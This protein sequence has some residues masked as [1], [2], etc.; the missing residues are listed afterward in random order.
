MTCRDMQINNSKENR[1][2]L[3]KIGW[4]VYEKGVI[5]FIR[6]MGFKPTTH[7]ILTQ[8]GLGHHKANVTWTESSMVTDPDTI[9]ARQCLTTV[10][11]RDP[12]HATVPRGCK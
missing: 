11:A 4:I 3:V 12:V 8:P 2:K 10:I 5:S 1:F 9:H 6:C 7:I